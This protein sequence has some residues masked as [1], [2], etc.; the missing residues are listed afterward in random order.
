MVSTIALIVFHEVAARTGIATGKGMA[1]L[2]RERYGRRA[3]LVAISALLVANL[4]T[5]C[6]EF[7]GVAAGMGL[8]G[9][10]PWVSV[11]ITAAGVIVL[12]VR[13][14]FRRI[15]HLLLALSAVFV[16]YVAAGYLAH[17]AWGAV[18][19][20][21][22][23]PSLPGTGAGLLAAVACLGTTLA[24][25]GLTFVQSYV[26]DK[27]LTLA[28]LRYE[29]IDVVTGAVMTGVIGAFVVV[30]CAATLHPLGVHIHD[31]SDAAEAL[32][33]V[34]G[35]LAA[36]LFGVGF[37]GAALLAAAI[38]PLSTAYSVAEALERPADI[39]DRVRDAPLF[40]G[41]FFLAVVLSAALV[42]VPGAPLIT[43]LFGSQ[44]LNAVLLLAVL[45]FLRAL[46][47]DRALMGEARLGTIG[48][49]ATAAAIILVAVSVVML[50]I[51]QLI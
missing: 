46:A 5:L 47:R 31:A 1:R 42:I 36:G 22:F 41:I 8:A 34:A 24:P 51:L 27:R 7:A 21:T 29:R 32:R 16:A 23:M 49:W 48:S 44:V 2:V 50:G 19:R 45:P 9:V 28:Q 6:A 26:V 40:Y 13:G 18:A 37:V 4:G 3:A 30:A 33:P 35:S 12:V 39:D 38:V 11:P 15:E 43:I 20:G 10:P 25:W 14:S 17:T